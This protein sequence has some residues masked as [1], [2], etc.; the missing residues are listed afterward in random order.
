MANRDRS[1]NEL[2]ANIL[3]ALANVTRVCIIENLK[4]SP[5]NVTELAALLGESNSITSRHL[6][7]LKSAGLIEDEKTGTTVTYS[8]AS[9]GIPDILD[10]VDEVIKMNYEKY[11]VFFSKELIK[12]R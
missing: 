4:D 10:S 6:N 12:E 9:N 7:V 1:R 11:H 8:L 5:Y 3:K 2:R